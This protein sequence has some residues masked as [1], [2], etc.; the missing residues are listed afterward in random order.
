MTAKNLFL[1]VKQ[2]LYLLFYHLVSFYPRNKKVWL[3]GATFRD[4]TKY[5]FLY[6]SQN[7]PEIKHVWISPKVEVVEKLRSLGLTAYRRNSFTS[8]YYALIAKVYICHA[9][10]KEIIH[11]CF[12]GSAILFNL[13]HGVG[14]KKIEYDI[15]KG[16][17]RPKVNPKTLREKFLSFIE[18]PKTFRNAS[19]VLTTGRE[20]ALIFSSA[21][22]L[23]LNKVCIG[24][25]PR[26]TVLLND[27]SQLKK[28]IEKFESLELAQLSSE[29]SNY[30]VVIIYMPTYRDINPNFMMEAISDF[31]RL[32]SLCK[33][34]N[35]LFLI[36]SHVSTRFSIDLSKYSNIRNLDGAIDIYP[37]LPFTDALISDYSSIIL[38]YSFLNK[39]I[40][41][42]PFDKEQYLSKDREFYFEYEEMFT[43][44]YLASFDD[45]MKE[46]ETLSNQ[47][48]KKL[49]FD[50]PNCKRFF[51]KDLEIEDIT[52]FIKKEIS[53]YD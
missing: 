29:L 53:Y 31:D 50:Y 2:C 8:I 11:P 33:K 41:F 9:Q 46:L 40:I 3:Y 23:P 30:A 52:K 45:L 22:K 39:K 27:F 47:D 26:N 51:D 19:A 28:H 6:A 48:M 42:Y 20:M 35:F 25:Y 37:L 13:W 44:D 32:H 1:F 49:T 38:D 16:P 18:E 7:L 5:F 17:E 12:R 36:K 21:F 34:N 4:N 43:S 15:T 14:I 10:P 24:P